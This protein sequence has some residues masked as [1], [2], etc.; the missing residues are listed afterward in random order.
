MDIFCLW[1]EQKFYDQ[2]IQFINSGVHRF[3]K[4]QSPQNSRR[5]NGHMT[6]VTQRK[7]PH[8]S[9]GVLTKFGSQGDLEAGICASLDYNKHITVMRRP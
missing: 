5:Q 6:Q 4:I 7:T 3:S 1:G 9:D 2:N 8:I